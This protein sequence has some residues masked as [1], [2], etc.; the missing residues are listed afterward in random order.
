MTL[1]KQIYHSPLGDL[2][3][4]A[5]E[6]GLIG[7][8]FVGQ[9]YF[10]QGIS[11][12]AFLEA[13]N[14]VLSQAKQWLDAYFAGEKPEQDKLVLSPRGTPFQ[15]QVWQ[16][17]REI[18]LGQTQTYG[19]IAKKINCHSAQA[20]GGAVSRNPLS[21]IVPCHR[22]LGSNGQLTGYAGGIDKKIWLLQHEG[23][24]LDKQPV[25]SLR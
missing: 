21:I 18:P 13:A 4:A 1:Y 9:K 17:L 8:W 3:L 25:F 19:E 11:H 7:I 16:A 5:D 15:K 12:Q 22:V 24:K 14:P 2:S 23:V 10:E 6:Q 20:V